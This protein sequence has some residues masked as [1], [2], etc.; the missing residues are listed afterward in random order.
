[1][2]KESTKRSKEHESSVDYSNRIEFIKAKFGVLMPDDF[3]RFYEFCQ[4]IK[5][6]AP[7]GI[8]GICIIVV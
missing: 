8:R 7:L 1:M 4:E 3:F 5:P 6:T 2:E